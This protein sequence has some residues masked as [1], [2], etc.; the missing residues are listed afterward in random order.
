MFG[1]LKGWI[2]GSRKRKKI[3]D[4]QD[5]KRFIELSLELEDKIKDEYRQVG[6]TKRSVLALCLANGYV[7]RDR[8]QTRVTNGL[9]EDREINENKKIIE[10]FDKLISEYWE[11]LR[12]LNGEIPDI[13]EQK[14]EPEASKPADTKKQGARLR[15]E[16]EAY[17]ETAANALFMLERR[18]VVTLG[19]VTSQYAVVVF[20]NE[21]ILSGK[22]GDVETGER[23]LKALEGIGCVVSEDSRSRAV[24]MIGTIVGN[25][26]ARG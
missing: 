1:S 6:D 14:A 16:A 19:G 13:G 20:A 24:S 25:A 9:H 21:I 23:V 10:V 12:Q 5:H 17:I 2:D 26:R 7:Q 18:Q 4:E 22:V 11:E 15:P 8:C 3:E